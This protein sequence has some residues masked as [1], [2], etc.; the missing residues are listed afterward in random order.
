VA[1]A[2][3]V[4]AWGHFAVR[5]HFASDILGG[6]VLGAAAASALGWL[7]QRQG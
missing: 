4:A 5:D 2:L 6:L 1:A 3:A 7:S